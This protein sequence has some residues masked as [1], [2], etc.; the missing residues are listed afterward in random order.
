MISEIEKQI[1]GIIPYENEPVAH[2][3]S[4]RPNWTD[5]SINYNAFPH[6]PDTAIICTTWWGHLCFLKAALT[7]YRSTGKFVICSYDPPIKPWGLTQ[8]SFVKSMPSVDLFLLAHSWVFKHI[9]YDDPKRNGWYWDVRYAQ[10]IINQ[11]DNIKYIFTVNGDCVWE[12]PEGVNELIELLG[13]ND[14]MSVSS[15]H[16]TIHTCA[17]LYRKEAFNSLLDYMSEYH[18]IQIPGSYSPERLLLDG[19]N[20]LGLKEK[21]VDKQPADPDGHSVD[22]Y[23]RYGQPSTWNDIVGFRNVGAEWLTS[24][25]E[26]LDPIEKKFIDFR[27]FDM[28]FA[29]NRSHILKYYETGDRRYLY[30]C[31]DQNEDSWYDRV[32]YPVTH[33]GENP[34]IGN[35]PEKDKEFKFN[36]PI[37]F[38][39]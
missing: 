29:H 37:N 10:G 17:V 27:F 30:M 28:V 26:G 9:T 14:L 34:I 35:N 11:F 21:K 25:I 15:D 23:C 18:K 2:D 24:V 36:Q 13:D 12:K 7:G 22:H 32:Y 31:A 1:A 5:L 4:V 8:D 39:E 3:N 19:V 38:P 6:K 20:V 33:Y 16:N